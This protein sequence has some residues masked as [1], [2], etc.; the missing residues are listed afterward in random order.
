[1]NE[2]YDLLEDYINFFIPSVVCIEKIRT[3][4]SRTRRRYDTATT[5]YQR[6]L[7]HDT[8]PEEIK[9]KLR[10]KYATLN[11]KLLKEKIDRI[12]TKLLKIRLK[13]R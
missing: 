1:M 4:H 12:L 9:E 2:L 6:I 7:N 5:A 11:P 10:Q 13:L 3:S 8:I